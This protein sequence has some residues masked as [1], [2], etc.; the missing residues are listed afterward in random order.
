MSQPFSEEL[1]STSVGTKLADNSQ[2]AT[3]FDVTCRCQWFFTAF[4][5]DLGSD[6]GLGRI[7]RTRWIIRN[8]PMIWDELSETET[9]LKFIR[10]IHR[11]T[12]ETI[13][14]LL[15]PC[16]FSLKFRCVHPCS[17]HKWPTGMWHLRARTHNSRWKNSRSWQPLLSFEIEWPVV[18]VCVCFYL[19]DGAWFQYANIGKLVNQT[20]AI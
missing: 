14:T 2:A 10:D 17:T 20:E 6:L 8:Y 9:I 19:V 1:H 4:S 16:S 18:F 11:Q 5:D 13:C 15:C 12:L 7:I 3:I